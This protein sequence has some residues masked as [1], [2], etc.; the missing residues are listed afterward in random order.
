MCYLK[1]ITV[2]STSNMKET[3]K[4]S[5]ENQATALAALDNTADWAWPRLP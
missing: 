4:N 3:H 2:S 5:F 1:K